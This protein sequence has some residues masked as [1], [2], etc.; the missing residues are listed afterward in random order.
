MYALICRLF[1]HKLER[2]ERSPKG[3][4]ERMYCIR[5]R[6]YFAFFHPTMWFGRWDWDDEETMRT[7][8]EIS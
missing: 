1:R 3:E 2:V 6:R 7:L 8:K 4:L 5:C